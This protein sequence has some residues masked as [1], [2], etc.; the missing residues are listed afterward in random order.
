MAEDKKSPEFLTKLAIIADASQA[1]VGGKM[2][3]VFQV[4]NPE[5]SEVFAKI[6]SNPDYSKEEFKIEISGTD[7][8][9]ILDK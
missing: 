7:F 6:E 3:I 4:Q 8:I 9:F 1:L 5:F 2:T